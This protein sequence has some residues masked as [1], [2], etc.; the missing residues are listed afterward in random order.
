MKL[1]YDNKQVPPDYV[2]G[3]CKATGCKLWRESAT[4][5]PA[6]RCCDCAGKQSKKD[7]SAVDDYGMRSGLYGPTDQIGWFVPAVPSPDNKSFYTYT[8]VPDAAV[9]WWRALPTRSK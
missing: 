1:S 2:C 5:A 7:V 6:L 8:G 9:L 4:S 3:T